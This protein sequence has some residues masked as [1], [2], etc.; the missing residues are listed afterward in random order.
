MEFCARAERCFT[1][2]NEKVQSEES[3][4]VSLHLQF[5]LVKCRGRVILEPFAV[6]VRCAGICVHTF[7]N[8]HE[9][10]VVAMVSFFSY[11]SFRE[12]R[13]VA[14]DLTQLVRAVLARM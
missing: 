11:F 2:F 9:F 14:S 5:L 1:E 13:E 12:I 8:V 3:G 4:T 10:D 7:S 6:I